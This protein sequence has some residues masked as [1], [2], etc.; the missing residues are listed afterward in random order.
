[1]RGR[2]SQR[3]KERKSKHRGNAFESPGN[4]RTLAAEVTY[5]LFINR[6]REQVNRTRLSTTSNAWVFFSLFF[7]FSFLCISYFPSFFLSISL[8]LFSSFFCF[9]FFFFSV[10]FFFLLSSLIFLP[11]SFNFSLSLFFFFFFSFFSISFF[12]SFFW[13]CKLKIFFPLFLLSAESSLTF[14]VESLSGFSYLDL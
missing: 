3:E 1:M 6:G 13:L 14:W 5:A 8:Y 10:S 2:E 7:F 12:L 11:F 9:R 4:L